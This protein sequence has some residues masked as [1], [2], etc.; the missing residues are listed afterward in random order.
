MAIKRNVS[1]LRSGGRGARRVGVYFAW[2]INTTKQKKREMQE[3]NAICLLLVLESL[4]AN[5]F[6]IK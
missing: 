4:S 1:R 6:L 3:R 5:L 2:C